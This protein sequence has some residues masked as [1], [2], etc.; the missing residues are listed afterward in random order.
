[1]TKTASED[2][3][4]DTSNIAKINVHRVGQ[5]SYTAIHLM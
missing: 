4:I 3:G 1:M 5:A 2:V